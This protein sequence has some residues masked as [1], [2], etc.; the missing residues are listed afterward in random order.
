M[1]LP[2]LLGQAALDGSADIAMLDRRVQ[3]L[4]M[5]C[6]TCAFL[7]V[8]WAKDKAERLQGEAAENWWKA[9]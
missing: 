1:Q 5:L 4:V 6:C 2:V 8:R 3:K 9:F 7:P